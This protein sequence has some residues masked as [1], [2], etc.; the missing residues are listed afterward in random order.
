MHLTSKASDRWFTFKHEFPPTWQGLADLMMRE[1][2]SY[3][4]VEYQAALARMNQVGKVEQYME[5][6]TKLSRRAPG[7]STEMLVQ[8]FVGGLR[9]DIRGDVQAQNPH[10]LYEACK[11]ARVF[12]ARNDS[13]RSYFA[14]QAAAQKQYSPTASSA[15]PFSRF[16][17]P[18]KT[19]MLGQQFRQTSSLGHT[20]NTNKLSDSEFAARR[21]RNQCY[22]C[23]A[24]YT[25][26]HNCRKKGQLMMLE[27]VPD[28]EEANEQ[29]EETS[30]KE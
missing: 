21:A 4:R 29:V 28:E 7:F 10:T 18:N 20:G 24:V 19:A 14:K 17:T 12:E 9:E 3:S 30:D 6:F 5:D 15:T 2:S 11:L 1:F 16:S 23:D 26:G 22:F 25:K 13:Q 27:I 8:F